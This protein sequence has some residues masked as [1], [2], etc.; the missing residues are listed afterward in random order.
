MPHNNERITIEYMCGIIG[1]I[2]EQKAY[3]I[4]LDGLSKLE[5]R[6]YD[7]AGIAVSDGIR[8]E[9]KKAKGRLSNLCE[10]LDKMREKETE[11]PLFSGGAGIGHTR[12]ATHGAPSD[13]NSHPHC[14]GKV[15]LV[16]NGIIENYAALRQSMTELGRVFVSDT[17]TE[18]VAQLLDYYYEAQTGSD[19]VRAAVRALDLT[20]E[21]VRGSYALAVMFSD[22]PDVLFAVRRDSPLIVGLGKGE[23]FIASDI[24]AILNRTRDYYLI[25]EGEIALVTRENVRIVD[26]AM[27]DVQK[28]K[29]TADWNVD[30]AEKGGYPHFMLKEINE[31]P[32]TLHATVSPR[33]T[34]GN[35]KILF[36]EVGDT[37]EVQRLLIVGCGSAT[38]A[39]MVGKIAI[40]KLSRV[41]VETYIA[42]E[43]RYSDPIFREGDVV[44]IISQS[45]ETADTLAALRLAKE[46]GVPVWAVVNV[47]GSSI[48]READRI[49]YTWCGPEIAVATTKAYTAQIAALYMV[50]LRLAVDKK[51]LAGTELDAYVE[52]LNAL[53]TC[54]E[55]LIAD[56]TPYENVAK[57]YLVGVHDL[58]Y[59]GRGR[60]YATCCEGSLKLKE[61]SYMHSEAY[62]A[63][64]LKHGA[65]SLIVPGM[66]VI[67]VVTDPSL[68]EKTVSNVKE[69]K[70]R[71]AHVLLVC[72]EDLC[73]D[74]DCYDEKILIPADADLF[75]PIAT[76]VPLQTMAYYAA[77]QMGCDVDKPRNL[78]KSVT[79]E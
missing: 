70:A 6:G 55:K 30:A 79:V 76:I 66:P 4:I 8:T 75:L 9:V 78:A 77:V 24:P 15:T 53:P 31:Q 12:W 59:I 44:V 19:R 63:G 17:D 47:V 40:E 64:E 60:D 54:V 14:S 49:I 29:L 43:F 67:A 39:G 37:S 56:M 5:Y 22:I 20:L 21:R 58:F 52:Q 7:S 48:A 62:A 3:K 42:S 32:R 41:P 34:N 16:H 74:A 46:R 18:S 57:R 69:C 27:Q 25:E 50:A 35:E 10:Q 68:A 13:I 51:L 23:N 71:G 65:I 61:I 1:Y 38:H 45:G 36:D 26:H 72:R 73:T 28:T 33:L 2:G 11:S